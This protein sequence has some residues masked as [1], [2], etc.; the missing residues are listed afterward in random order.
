MRQ[1]IT[2]RLIFATLF[3]L[4]ATISLNAVAQVE[5][6]AFVNANRILSETKL[7][8]QAIAKLKSDFSSREAEIGKLSADIKAETSDLEKNGATM[9]A[10]SLADEQRKLSEMN[11]DLQRKSSQYKED[12]SARQRED[13]QKVLDVANQQ[14][15]VI[16]KKGNWNMVL[17]NAVYVNPSV[18][19]TND[20]IK[21][22]DEQP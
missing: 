12:L 15:Q 9:A 6:I 16:A 3:C 20:V 13:I 8:K 5:R 22:M 4:S 7:A 21:A 17:R 19:I 10:S 14:I 1:Q 2:P 11:R 18:D